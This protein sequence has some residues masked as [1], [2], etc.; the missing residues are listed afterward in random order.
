ME[1]RFCTLVWNPA[2]VWHI[3]LSAEE[4]FRHQHVPLWDLNVPLPHLYKGKFKHTL[5]F[6]RSFGYNK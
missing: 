2:A 3:F 5:V 6:K 4:V 1:V